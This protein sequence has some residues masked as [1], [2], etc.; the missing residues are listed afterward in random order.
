MNV[1]LRFM[2]GKRMSKMCLY[3]VVTRGWRLAL[4]GD[5]WHEDFEFRL[6]HLAHILSI[7]EARPNGAVF[8]VLRCRPRVVTL[9]TLPFNRIKV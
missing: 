1:G 6:S 7:H 5:Y 8:Q 2:G 4:A 9:M 3:A